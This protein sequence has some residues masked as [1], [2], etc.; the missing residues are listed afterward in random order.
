[1]DSLKRLTLG[2][3]FDEQIQQVKWPDSLEHVTFVHDFNIKPEGIVCPYSAAMVA[4]FR[5]AGIPT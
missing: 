3:C 2:S 5:E 1:M 4:S